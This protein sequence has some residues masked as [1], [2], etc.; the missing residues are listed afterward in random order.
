[1]SVVSPRLRRPAPIGP[2]STQAAPDHRRG[3]PSLRIPRYRPCRAERDGRFHSRPPADRRPRGLRHGGR[4]LTAVEKRSLSAP[5]MVGIVTMSAGVAGFSAESTPRRKTLPAHAEAA[6]DQS[7]R[8]GESSD[9]M[10][11]GRLTLPS[12][13]F[14]LTPSLRSLR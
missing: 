1:L 12:S 11:A 9:E 5:D 8:M 4:V 13:R 6:L 7:R 10:V 3:H 2:G 14:C